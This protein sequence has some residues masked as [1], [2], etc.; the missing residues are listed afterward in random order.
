MHSYPYH[1]ARSLACCPV[2]LVN[3][4]ATPGVDCVLRR[5]QQHPTRPFRAASQQRQSPALLARPG[6]AGGSWL[7]T[8]RSIPPTTSAHNS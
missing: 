2:W 1:S 6:Q 8:A 7:A 5:R 3:S 4:P